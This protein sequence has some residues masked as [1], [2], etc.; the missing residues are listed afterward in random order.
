[1]LLFIWKGKGFIAF[2]IPL[3]VLCAVV[4]PWW[5]FFGHEKDY[6]AIF[7]TGFIY[8]PL[9]YVVYKNT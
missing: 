2:L 7:I 4:W 9:S 3:V 6:Y 1:M 5:Y 8:C